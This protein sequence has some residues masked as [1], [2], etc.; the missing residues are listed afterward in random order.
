MKPEKLNVALEDRS[1]FSTCSIVPTGACF[2]RGMPRLEPTRT[3]K[4]LFEGAWFRLD[5]PLV[6]GEGCKYPG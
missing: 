2:G 3:R 5:T 4:Y 6:A 1:S